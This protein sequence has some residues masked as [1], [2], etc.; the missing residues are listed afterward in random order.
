MATEHGRP[1]EDDVPDGPRQSSR[2]SR[3]PTEPDLLP[4][5]WP[6]PV[7]WGARIGSGGE[8]LADTSDLVPLAGPATSGADA[9]TGISDAGS[10][11]LSGRRRPRSRIEGGDSGRR[12]PSMRLPSVGILAAAGAITGL[13]GLAGLLFLVL[14]S[15]GGFSPA[16]QDG[17]DEA[18][19]PA[20]VLTTVRIPDLGATSR[21]FG[22]RMEEAAI[23]RRRAQHRREQAAARLEARR[24]RAAPAPTNRAATTQVAAP[25]RATTPPASASPSSPSPAEREFTP[26]PWNLS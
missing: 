24:H 26:G 12:R 8:V 4:S 11:V 13:L 20:A 19:V 10:R 6:G 21:A 14:F 5:D 18:T 3:R 16:T 17:S 1:Y 23:E 15:F 7:T 22:A 25:P 2:A 9:S